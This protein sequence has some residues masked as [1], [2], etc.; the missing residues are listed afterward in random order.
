MSLHNWASENGKGPIF[1]KL[2]FVPKNVNLFFSIFC[3]Y[4]FSHP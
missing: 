1:R 2:S 4:V 3:V